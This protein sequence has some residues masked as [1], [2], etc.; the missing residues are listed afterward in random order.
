MR[1]TLLAVNGM[2]EGHALPKIANQRFFENCTQQIASPG[3]LSVKLVPYSARA[4]AE[5]AKL[6]KDHLGGFCENAKPF[7]E[8]C[9]RM[10]LRGRSEF[11]GFIACVV[12][13]AGRSR[14]FQNLS[15]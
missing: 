5:E 10:R 7:G 13:D 8:L 11:P 9:P 6:K 14:E 4:D 12:L 3:Q 1:S 2:A 15:G